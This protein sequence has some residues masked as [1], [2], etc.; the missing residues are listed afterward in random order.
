MEVPLTDATAR[1]TGPTTDPSP[2][3]DEG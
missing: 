1:A 2:A 3:P